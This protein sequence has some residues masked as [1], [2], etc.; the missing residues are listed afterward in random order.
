MKLLSIDIGIINLSFCLFEYSSIV[1]RSKINI[2]KWENINITKQNNHICT[3]IE[4]NKKCNKVAKLMKDGE[5]FCLKHSKKNI[6]L[7]PCSELKKTYLNKQKIQRLIEIADK[8]NIHY[9]LPIKKSILLNIINDYVSMNCFSII[10][11]QKCSKIDLVT[12][13]RNI[14][15]RFDT[16][17]NNE[18]SEINKI[19]IENQIGPIANKMKTIQGMVAQYFIMKNNNITI[20]FV[21]SINKLKDFIHPSPNPVSSPHLLNMDNKLNMIENKI[22]NQDKKLDYKERKKLSIQITQNFMT[23]DN[24]FICWQEFFNSNNKKDDLS[25]CFLQ[26]LYFIYSK[27]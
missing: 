16:L 21:S 4:K 14:Q 5:Y 23:N 20:E 19:I 15:E 17:L 24:R 3:Y 13:G 7:V 22:I 11:K 18:M 8:Y 12:I 26:G 25:D 2:V 1:D 9:E 6:F 27:I 10:E